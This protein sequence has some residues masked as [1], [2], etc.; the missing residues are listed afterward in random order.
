MTARRILT[1]IETLGRGGA[2]RLLVT[3]HR[4]LDGDRFRAMVV[5]LFEPTPLAAELEAAGAQVERLALPGPRAFPTAV[6]RLRSLIRA[7]KP[8]VVHTHLYHANVA[9]RIAAAGLAPVFTTLHNPDYGF[10]DPGTVRFRA[11]KWL[12]GTTGRR[13]TSR[14]I[15]VSAHVRRDFERELG[16]RNVDLLHNFVDV[17][18]FTGPL[19]VDERRKRRAALGLPVDGLLFLHVG[20]LHRQKGQDLLLEALASLPDHPGWTAVLVGAGDPRHLRDRARS[21]GVAGRVRWTGVV[22]DVRPYYAA[23][24]VF[25]FPSRYEAFGIALVEAMASGLPSA[26]SDAAGMSEVVTHETSLITPVGDVQA[27]AAA[28]SRLG[29]DADL[30]RSLGDAARARARAF[31]VRCQLPRLERWYADA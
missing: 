16:F 25:A 2:E 18:D 11:K 13:L 4:H 5:A 6:R 17:G 7:W 3:Q 15:A 26:V 20:R 24:D 28:L 10:E 29:G 21:L 30:R 22:A 8:D 27:L 12:D 19:G 14:I 31:D 23:A 1:V 9:G